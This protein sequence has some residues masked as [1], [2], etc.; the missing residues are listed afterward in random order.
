MC[1]DWSKLFFDRSKLSK[2]V[3]DVFLKLSFRSD[4]HFFK[5]FFAF[6]LSIRLGF[7]SFSPIFFLQ[8]FPLPRLVR[9]LYPSFYIY[10][11]V[12]MHKLMHFC[13]IFGTFQNWDFCW[14]NPLFL[15]LIIGFCSCIVIFMIYV[16]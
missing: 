3:W 6:S 5:K 2:I 10:F 9:P 11:H 12:F 14:I 1:F 8:G 13:E 15:K 4:K 16:G 7:L